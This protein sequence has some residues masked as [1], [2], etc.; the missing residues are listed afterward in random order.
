MQD[1]GCLHSERHSTVYMYYVQ[2]LVS[3]E[4]LG[5][6]AARELALHITIRS[7]DFGL[8]VIYCKE[9]I[10]KRCKVFRNYSE[11]LINNY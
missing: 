6:W 5:H 2:S 10:Y 8:D 9:S 3:L 11:T 7:L 4:V 1:E